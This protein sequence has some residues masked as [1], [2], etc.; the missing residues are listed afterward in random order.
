[1]ARRHLPRN[2]SGEHLSLEEAWDW[3]EF[4]DALIG[5]EKA[6]TLDAL[7][8][9]VAL[10]QPRYFAKTRDELV[11]FFDEQRDEL[12]NA[13][14][15]NLLA[16]TEAAL[17]VD[18]LVRVINKKKDGISKRFAL[19]YKEYGLKVG[20]EEQILDCW[21]QHAPA[22]A[23]GAIGQFNGAL[24]LRH[25]LA[26]GRYWKS[27]LGRVYDP[28]DVFEICDALLKATVS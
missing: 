11:E 25:W 26:H 4:Q 22:A 24:N 12:K 2:L 16:A 13:V 19:L 7:L 8:T 1:M 10:D 15:L 17:R 9:G 23:R 6:R 3:Y 21:K 14:M 18:Y 5:A 20:L 28:Q 27:R